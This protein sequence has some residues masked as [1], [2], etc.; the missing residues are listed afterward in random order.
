[1]AVVVLAAGEGKRMR[2]RTAKV[3][4][5][6]AGK[7]LVL[8]VLDAVSAL[9]PERSIVVV[10][11][12]GDQVRAAVGERAQCVTQAEQLGS[13][14]A[15]LQARKALAGFRGDV[16]VLCGDAPL[17]RTETL[18]TLRT[19]HA[20]AGAAATV[21][22][23]ELDDPASYGRVIDDGAGRVRIVEHADANSEERS[24]RT[25]N[26]GTYDFDADFLF[27]ALSRVG[28][29]NAQG[30]YYLT[31]LMTTASR[32]GRANVSVLDDPSEGLG[33]NSRLDLARAEAVLQERLVTRWLDAGV[34]FLDPSTVYL[35]ADV[36]IGK[37]SV[38]GPNVRL[39]GATTI[40]EGC[41]LEGSCYLKDTIVD[42]D[43]LVR[44]GVVAD[45][46]RIGAGAR[47]GPYSHL[48]PEADL[49]PE[50]HIGNFVEV[51]KARIGRGSKANHL[52]YIGDATIGVDV[53]VGAGTIT[54]NYDGF[55]K[56]R[57]VIGDRVQIGS[58]TQLVAPVTLGE[59]VYVA[60]GSTVTRDVEKGALV[61]NDKPQRVR[62][63][64]VAGF[65]KKAKMAKPTKES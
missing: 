45:R 50:V 31:D 10:G 8:H 39:D 58:D 27:K 57:T 47:I 53:N 48:R 36:E 11:H 18:R 61:F 9:R 19:K 24:I 30:E 60:A 64:W 17:L 55:R 38:I 51:K 20:R 23:M 62:A 52:A 54:C 65:R 43:A 44:W 13:A 3:L 29:N 28:R 15:T 12:C 49:G 1:L 33:I 14:H 40:G 2:S 42:A 63:G 6:L 32:T 25:V 59:D 37:D 26:S 35:S 34:T 22:A 16:L 21:L 7:P 46:A 41:V 5:Q 56:H 4:H